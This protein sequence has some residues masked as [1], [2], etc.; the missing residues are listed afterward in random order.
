M[1][2][3]FSQRDR[4]CL[5]LAAARLWRE[6]HRREEIKLARKQWEVLRYLAERPG[7]LVSKEELI[8]R[9]WGV[10]TDDSLNQAVR[11]IRTAIGD[12]ARI[13]TVI[14]TVHGLGYRFVA[15]LEPVDSTALETRHKT[16]PDPFA[17]V[18]PLPPT[19]LSRHEVSD[20]LLATLVDRSPIPVIVGIE[21]M[22]GAGKTLLAIG[23]CNE[24]RIRQTFDSIVWLT[25]GRQFRL[26]FEEYVQVIA[27]ALS[28]T[29][30]R[31][32]EIE[33]RTIVA[34][35]AVLVVLDDIWELRD[36]EPFRIAEGRS[37]ILYTS[38]NCAIAGSLGCRSHS[39]GLLEDDTARSLLSRWSGRN[40]DP[41]PEPHASEIL[42]ECR[43]LPL[44]LAMIGGALNGQP[45]SEWAHTLAELKEG[46]L[47]DF[48]VRP[49]G[50]A[51][52]TFHASMAV[53]VNMLT[54]D[55][56]HRYLNLA[57]LLED[58]PAPITL[59]MQI[60]GQGE[61]QTKM[62]ARILLDRSLLRREINGFRV[63]DLQLDYLRGEYPARTALE[64]MSKALL[65]A[66]HVVRSFPDQFASQME[67][68]LLHCK[69]DDHIASFLQQAINGSPRPRFRALISGLASTI[70]PSRR[71]YQLDK[72]HRFIGPIATAHDGRRIVWT[73]RGALVVWDLD[74][75]VPPRT[76][77]SGID[78]A[79][80][81]DW[82]SGP[83]ITPDGNR[84]ISSVRDTLLVWDLATKVRVEVLRGHKSEIT[85]IGM[86]GDGAFAVTGAAD[87]TV[88]VWDLESRTPPIEVTKCDRIRSVGLA[89]NGRRAVI[90]G[91]DKRVFGNVLLI[92]DFDDNPRL[93]V[94]RHPNI[95]SLAVTP[96]G[97]RAIFSDFDNVMV[98]DLDNAR[99]VRKLSHGGARNPLDTRDHIASLALVGQ[100]KQCI[101]VSRAG[102]PLLWD[103]DGTHEPEELVGH[104]TTF[105][106]EFAIA[107]SEKHVS[108]AYDDTLI[109]WRIESGSWPLGPG[110]FKIHQR[111][112]ALSGA[113]CRL[114][115]GSSNGGVYV[116]DTRRVTAPPEHMYVSENFLDLAISED[117][118]R[119]SSGIFGDVLKIWDL[120]HETPPLALRLRRESAWID[121][122]ALSGDGN[123]AVVCTNLGEVLRWE[124][125]NEELSLIWQATEETP[126]KLGVKRITRDGKRAICTVAHSLQM[127][128][129]DTGRVLWTVPDVLGDLVAVSASGSRLIGGWAFGI[130]VW[131]LNRPERL[132]RL[133]T[134]GVFTALA[135]SEDGTTAVVGF[136]DGRVEMWNLDLGHRLATFSCDVAIS[137]CAL[138]EQYVAVCDQIGYLS[139]LRWEE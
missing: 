42:T 39:L 88:L 43:G 107:S 132:R 7:S 15:E 12:R 41:L 49:S 136:L 37:A 91:Y 128:D 138:G 35:R 81:L 60:W 14:E 104:R 25:F 105:G 135:V 119:A 66:S 123:R 87:G 125:G 82:R 73:S 47:K 3:F 79:G 30:E 46:R 133:K 26:P 54:D 83:A 67:S 115:A 129:L 109:Q 21:G 80:L 93:R 71:V 114:M 50:Y 56:K 18:P 85:G 6:G 137:S 36:L 113:A 33:Y 112:L 117:G 34:Q 5:D 75:D 103:T 29:C 99:L 98:L 124:R 4:F 97:Q 102:K 22:G 76:I 96:D 100:G 78:E 1:I 16:S 127:W 55:I 74:T 120:D 92:L 17:S 32:S 59:L 38:R 86:P 134:D 31:Y 10:G 9:V 58:M 89:S 101:T 45:D 24:P 48:G 77:E 51:Y 69:D 106:Q 61:R 57:I 94:L 84:V 64:S 95:E 44:A 11:K 2:A 126:P 53:S 40:K 27:H 121:G 130:D 122:I 131:D 90:V 108:A 65:L 52:D 63:H 139:L 8:E 70:G 68:R 23:L 13:P 116:W 110:M 111:A 19:Y 28:V 62:T 20:S 72:G 118:R